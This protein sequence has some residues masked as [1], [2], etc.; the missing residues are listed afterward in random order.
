MVIIT[1]KYHAVYAAVEGV[2]YSWGFLKSVYRRRPL[3][4]RKG[5]DNFNALVNK[6]ICRK[7]LTVDMVRKFSR[8]AGWYMLAYRALKSGDMRR[9][10]GR[11][12]EITH[13]MIGKVEKETSSHCATLDFDMDYLEKVVTPE[14]YD[15][16]AE[17]K[18]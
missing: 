4:E 15:F 6:C 9:Q 7:L 2:D 14:G 17:F 5:K 18:S 11:A 12:T 1:T 8:R 13:K 10:A 16:V 3:V